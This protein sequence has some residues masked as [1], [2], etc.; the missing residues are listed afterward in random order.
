MIVYEPQLIQ[1]TEWG[2]DA[3]SRVPLFS[4][5]KDGARVDY[6]MPAAEHPGMLLEYLQLARMQGEELAV[7][8]LLEKALGAEGYLALAREPG[9]TSSTLKSISRRIAEVISGRA[10]GVDYATSTPNGADA[11]PFTDTP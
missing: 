6:D 2:A 5:V 1:H 11:D 4:I 3:L 7:S 9:L 8:W 10:P